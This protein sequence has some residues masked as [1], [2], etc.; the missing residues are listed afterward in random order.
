M[1]ICKPIIILFFLVSIGFFQE[2][3]I[4]RYKLEFSHISE[5]DLDEGF[6]TLNYNFTSPLEIHINSNEVW[7]LYIQ[8]NGANLMSLDAQIPIQNIQWKKSSENDGVY[9]PLTYGKNWIASSKQYSNGIIELNFKLNINWD[10]YPGDYTLPIEFIIDYQ[11][12]LLRKRKL[13]Q[14]NTLR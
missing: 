5:L 12:N 10:S 9:K 7:D 11:P 8:P 2:I 13:T 4:S 1:I 14:K 3:N 6:T